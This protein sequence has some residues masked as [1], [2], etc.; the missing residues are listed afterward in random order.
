MGELESTHYIGKN[1]RKKVIIYKIWALGKMRYVT[2][3]EEI[4]LL[5]KFKD[6]I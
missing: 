3:L 5:A 1:K 4:K 6:A 2:D